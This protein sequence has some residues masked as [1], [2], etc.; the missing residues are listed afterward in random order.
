M[1][2][3]KEWLVEEGKKGEARRVRGEKGE[4]RKGE[5]LEGRKE[6]VRREKD[7]RKKGRTRK[8]KELTKLYQEVNILQVQL[9]HRKIL[10]LL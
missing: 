8:K 6:E 9:Y 5:E 2:R 4:A 3:K 7:G 1:R 10:L